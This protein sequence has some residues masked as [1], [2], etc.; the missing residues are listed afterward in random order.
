MAEKAMEI[1]ELRGKIKKTTVEGFYE[2]DIKKDN[3]N[4][5]RKLALNSDDDKE[6][7]P[8]PL[9]NK[10]QY[11]SQS[12]TPALTNQTYCMEEYCKMDFSLLFIT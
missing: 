3:T 6:N 2:R 4:Y 9:E 5:K 8:L 10:Q 1:R 7:I 11:F 12:R